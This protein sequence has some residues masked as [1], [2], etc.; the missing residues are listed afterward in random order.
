LVLKIDLRSQ[1]VD[2]GGN[3]WLDDEGGVA[4]A[5]EINAIKFVECSAL[6]MGGVKE[7]FDTAIRHVYNG[8]CKSERD[9]KKENCVVL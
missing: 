2:D 8:R 9:G 3:G 5:T 4:L 7:V 1:F 6:T